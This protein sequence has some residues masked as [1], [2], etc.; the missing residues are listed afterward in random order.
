MLQQ[1]VTIAV[2][3][4]AIGVSGHTYY[5]WR[6]EYGGLRV[7]Q[8]GYN[9]RYRISALAGLIIAPLTLLIYTYSICGWGADESRWASRTSTP[10]GGIRSVFGG[11]DSHALPPKPVCPEILTPFEGHL[12]QFKPR[13]D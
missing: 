10:L 6:K 11:F 8:A 5:R 7:E 13:R 12:P 9:H 2:I 3:S 1:G 4:K